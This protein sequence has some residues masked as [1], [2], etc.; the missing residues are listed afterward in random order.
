MIILSRGTMTF[1][2]LLYKNTYGCTIRA[3]YLRILGVENTGGLVTIGQLFVKDVDRRVSA[4][5]VYLLCQAPESEHGTVG[6][7]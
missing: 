3:K 5:L 1:F 6:N 4:T 7:V 2:L